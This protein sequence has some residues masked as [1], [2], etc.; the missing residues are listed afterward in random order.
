MIKTAGTIAAAMTGAL[1]ITAPVGA[2]TIPECKGQ[3]AILQTQTASSPFKNQKDEDGLVAKLME[4]SAKLDVAKLQDASQKVGDYL[5]KLN[6]LNTQGKIEDKTGQTY[7]ELSNGAN[8]VQY[9]IGNI[10]K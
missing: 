3:I 5:T 10:G 1:L 2:T 7:S 8:G 4:G 6:Q 9:C